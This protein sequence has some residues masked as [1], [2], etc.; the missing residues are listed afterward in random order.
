MKRNPEIFPMYRLPDY[1]VRRGPRT[2]E[3]PRIV[4]TNLD[5][6]HLRFDDVPDGFEM[7]T[8]EFLSLIHI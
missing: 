8:K 5:G 4:L 2:M 6:S 7:S 3:S 1:R